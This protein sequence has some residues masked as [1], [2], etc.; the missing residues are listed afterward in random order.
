MIFFFLAAIALGAYMTFYP[1]YKNIR[2]ARAS[3]IPYLI[4][5]FQPY[6]Y[7]A[8]LTFPI[9]GR[10]FSYLPSSWIFPDFMDPDLQWKKLYAP[11]RRI[12]ADTV[13][14]CSPGQLVL[15]TAGAEVI[16]QVISRKEDFPKPAQLYKIVDIFG[17]SVIST[18]GHEWRKHR[19]ALSAVYTHRTYKL[20][21]DES[22]RHFQ[23]LMDAFVGNN[24]SSKDLKTVD[25]SVNQATLAVIS[26][27]AYGVSLHPTIPSDAQNKAAMH[28]IPVANKSQEVFQD[29]WVE[30]KTHGHTL[31]YVKAIRGITS[32]ILWIACVPK[33]LLKLLPFE[34]AQYAFNAY[35][36][37][38]QYMLEMIAERR[39]TMQSSSS[40]ANDLLSNLVKST[41]SRSSSSSKFSGPGF[42]DEELLADIFITMIGGHKTT[43][44]TIR[45][46][47]LLLAMNVSSQRNLQQDIDRI[48]QRKKPE[49]WDYDEDFR[50]LFQG[51]PGAVIAEVLR[52]LPPILS[53][54]KLTT[55]DQP[56]TIDG[57]ESTVPSGTL[58]AINVVAAHRNPKQWPASEDGSDDLAT[59]KPERW[60]CQ[61]TS[62]EKQHSDLGVVAEAAEITTDSVDGMYKPV[63]GSYLPFSAGGR[64]CLGRQFAQTEAIIALAIIFREYSVELSVEEWAS[65]EEVSRMRAAQKRDVWLKAHQKALYKFSNNI[66]CLL[67]AD[68][69]GE[70]IP[71]RFVR[72][73]NERF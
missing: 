73:G 18:E 28:H 9:W 45:F 19:R 32:N 54:P 24:V 13:L 66:E 8:R 5:P 63:P 43:A 23:A 41:E 27:A 20:V 62:S 52:W 25:E 26:H 60:L 4:I 61:A 39:R 35:K 6:T 51:M 47:I 58:V 14:L 34:K 72:R 68:M 59:F 57:S 10:L 56:I 12:N 33:P 1:F 53:V 22:I 67:S 7:G 2:A 21:W 42:T 49:E 30:G 55:Q 44:T 38:G 64:I 31:P 50:P 65:D 70:P 36:S 37:F 71:V 17:P 29:N 15:H 16:S 40:N 69:Q 48:L 3:N 11:F 46:G